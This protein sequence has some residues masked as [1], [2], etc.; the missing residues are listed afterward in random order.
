MYV[1]FVG[2]WRGRRGSNLGMFRDASWTADD[3][4]VHEALRLAIREQLDWFNAK[5]PAPERRFFLVKSRG[6]WLPDGICWF[7]DDAREMIA[8]AFALA[9]LLG[10]CGVSMTKIATR[11]PGQILYRDDWQ[12]VARPEDGSA[13]GQGARFLNDHDGG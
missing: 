7:L 3:S 4:R 13:G 6:A 2:L 11:A 12:I 10:E 9:A 1:R 5:L 8:R